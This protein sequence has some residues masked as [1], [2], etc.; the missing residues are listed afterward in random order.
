M[1]NSRAN[2]KSY[3]KEGDI[4]VEEGD[5]LVSS[6]SDDEDKAYL[7]LKP[8]NPNKKN[9]LCKTLVD[10]CKELCFQNSLVFKDFDQ[11]FI[12][13]YSRLRY[14]ELFDDEEISQASQCLKMIANSGQLLNLMAEHNLFK[15]NMIVDNDEMKP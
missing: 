14:W 11:I 13:V 12:K 8:A 3:K 10:Q 2:F 6:C 5:C 9:Y 7:A 15:L 4:I 1:R